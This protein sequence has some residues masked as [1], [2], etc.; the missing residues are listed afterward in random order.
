MFL[1]SNSGFSYISTYVS[2]INSISI[3]DYDDSYLEISVNECNDI[4]NMSRIYSKFK[5]ISKTTLLSHVSCI[6][7]D[8]INENIAIDESLLIDLIEKSLNGG[9]SQ[10]NG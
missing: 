7:Y 9:N 1:I 3:N 8:N 5:N 6:L 4:I 10:Q 2:S